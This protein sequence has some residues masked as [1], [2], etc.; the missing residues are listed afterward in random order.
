MSGQSD[1]HSICRVCGKFPVLFHWCSPWTALGVCRVCH[2]RLWR[3][4]G[5]GLKRG[6]LPRAR[7]RRELTVDNGQLTA[8]DALRAGDL[9]TENSEGTEKI[10]RIG[11]VWS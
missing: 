5:R 6:T 9:T 4:R 1:D 11:R 2:A 8:G 7:R 3:R 10:D